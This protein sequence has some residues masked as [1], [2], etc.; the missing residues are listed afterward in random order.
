MTTALAR[1]PRA[2]LATLHRDPRDQWPD[3]ARKLYDFL[4]TVYGEADPLPTLAAGW[5]ARSW[6][7]VSLPG[8]T[9]H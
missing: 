4:V 3:H 1:S 8:R 2:T 9:L 7:T 6:K 5:V